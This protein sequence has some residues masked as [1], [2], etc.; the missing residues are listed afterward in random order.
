MQQPLIVVATQTIEARADIDFDGLVTDAAALD[1]LRQ[2]F[3]RV[4]RAL[5]SIVPISTVLA[6]SE[7]IGT[8]ANDPV[9]GDRIVKTWD[10]LLIAASSTNGTVDFS[11]DA[12]P[13]HLIA[14]AGSLASPKPDA[15]VLLPAYA[16]LWSQTSP[17]PNADPE[18]GLF[19]HGPDRSPASIQIVW[20][21][22]VAEHDLIRV[23]RDRLIELLKLV[24]PRA[25]EAIEVPLWAARAWLLRQHE[26]L[27]YLSDATERSPEQ[28]RRQQRAPRVPVRR[29]R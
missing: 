7:D 16:D 13:Q 24:P 8:K 9:Y 23:N 14:A 6:H 18:V 29:C 10:A 11:I 27:T 20:R 5:R 25:T 15:P 1:A 12:F 17:V 22:D 19:L 4:N 2:R 26:A 21:A 28:D 3:G